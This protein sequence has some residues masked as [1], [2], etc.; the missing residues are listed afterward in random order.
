MMVGDELLMAPLLRQAGSF[1]L[2]E[3]AGKV[4][5]V[6]K[7]LP[8]KRTQ[9]VL[10]EREGPLSPWKQQVT[11]E[12]LTLGPGDRFIWESRG[13]STEWPR[14]SMYFSALEG[15]DLLSELPAWLLLEEESLVCAVPWRQQLIKRLAALPVPSPGLAQPVRAPGC[16]AQA[17]RSCHVFNKKLEFLFGTLFCSFKYL[18][19]NFWKSV[20]PIKGRKWCFWI[21][22]S[23][24]WLAGLC[25]Q[26][27]RRG[28]TTLPK[29]HLWNDG[30]AYFTRF[31]VLL[32]CKSIGGAQRKI[33]DLFLS[34]SESWGFFFYFYAESHCL[35]KRGP[36][37]IAERGCRRGSMLSPQ[38][39]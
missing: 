34:G 2:G 13:K 10:P 36:N 28:T 31:F 7:T 29:H 22:I 15:S 27:C 1:D 8:L 11:A 38:C 12:E 19:D 3:D 21:R 26:D 14:K 20:C 37:S 25:Q 6:G 4:L 24:L 33:S 18:Q 16:G 39:P 23:D 17:G 30:A 32:S 9:E 5:W 35:W